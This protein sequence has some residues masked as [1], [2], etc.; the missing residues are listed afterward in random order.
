MGLIIVETTA[1]KPVRWRDQRPNR[2]NSIECSIFID[3]VRSTDDS[4]KYA[5]R[6]AG[7]VL[8][9]QGIW[10]REPLPSSRSDEFLQAC[11]FDTFENAVLFAS[12]EN[13]DGV[14]LKGE[15]SWNDKQE[16]ET[17]KETEEKT[18]EEN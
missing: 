11:R 2:F 3:A 7:S 4:V 13:P 5:V 17:E 18:E 6:Q 12:K 8:S 10:Y 16:K 14:Y 9:K 1:F 15:L